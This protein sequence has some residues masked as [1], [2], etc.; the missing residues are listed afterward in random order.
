MGL[1]QKPS[2]NSMWM[3]G[4]FFPFTR[5]R[6]LKILHRRIPCFSDR[7]EMGWA[8]MTGL[9]LW[10]ASCPLHRIFSFVSVLSWSLQRLPRKLFNEG[11]S[12]P[13]CGPV[14]KEN[15]AKISKFT[16][17]TTTTSDWNNSYHTKLSPSE[18]VNPLTAHCSRKPATPLITNSFSWNSYPIKYALTSPIHA[19]SQDQVDFIRKVIVNPN[20]NPALSS[21]AL[22]F[23]LQIHFLVSHD[24]CT[25]HMYEIRCIFCPSPATAAS[26]PPHLILVSQNLLTKNFLIKI[27]IKKKRKEIKNLPMSTGAAIIV[28]AFLVDL[29]YSF[30]P[31]LWA[32]AL[33]SGMSSF[34]AT[35]S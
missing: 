27:I 6:C 5:R 31:G 2:S 22:Q 34:A 4:I 14:A 23:P 33:T 11:L 21:F 28:W 16:Q 9:A 18:P 8:V 7:S 32:W 1:P 25:A 10:V 17:V 29:T 12:F 24:I 19:G 15:R 35:T 13:W 20:A 3:S 30:S 26:S